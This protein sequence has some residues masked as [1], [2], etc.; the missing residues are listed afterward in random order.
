MA[1]LFETPTQVRQRVGST[2]TSG[3]SMFPNTGAAMIG[4]AIG[5]G[6]GGLFSEQRNP[7]LAR[8]QKLQKLQQD[9][10]STWDMS[11]ITP[12]TMP[13]VAQEMAQGLVSIGEPMMAMQLMKEVQAFK[14]AE[15]EDFTK[16]KSEVRNAE[17]A[18]IKT[19]DAAIANMR[20]DYNKLENLAEKAKGKGVT[21][22]AARNSMIANIVRLNSPGIVQEAELRTYTGGQ[23]TTSAMLS[24]LTGKG[25]D[26][27]AIMS[28]IDPSGENFDA[29]GML[30][31]GGALVLGKA[32]PIFD[33]IADSRTRAEQTGLSERGMKSIFSG[34]SNID[35]MTELQTKISKKANQGMPDD[36][37]E[38]RKK[39]LGL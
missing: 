39:A 31:L 30:S 3:A 17:R 28:Y 11:S 38:K 24:W 27:D 1:S 36:E 12:Q 5:G 33:Q 18:N 26:T 4:A 8:A 32:Q 14:P 16:I 35:A 6:L 19:A 34:T 10:A 29:E 7:E 25:Y 15:D 13:K 2:L 9:W 21:A 23:G 20:G 22:R 37:Y